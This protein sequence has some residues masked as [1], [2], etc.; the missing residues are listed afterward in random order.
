MSEQVQGET[1][2]KVGETPTA[3]APATPAT[4]QAERDAAA[5]DYERAMKTITEQR[6]QIKELSKAQKRLTDLE[7]AETKRQQAE[8]TELQKVQKEADELKAQLKKAQLDR[9]RYDAA[10]KIG[11]PAALAARLQGETPEELEADAKAILE[12]LPKQPTKPN[13]PNLSPT[14]PGGAQH[15]E[16]NAEALARIHGG[17]A[18]PWDVAALQQA[19]G[20]VLAPKMKGDNSP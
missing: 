16:T 5:F 14:N 11:I 6:E 4:T 10:Q 19:G 8:M 18:N 9:M 2:V 12:L 17:L 7:A 13:M 15:G 3:T 1:P 20:G